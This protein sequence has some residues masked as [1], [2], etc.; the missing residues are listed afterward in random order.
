MKPPIEQDRHQTLTYPLRLP[1]EVKTQL[2]AEA[3]K[4]RRSL[5]GEIV[6]R[7]EKSL[8]ADQSTSAKGAA[9]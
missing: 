2:A 7:L 4:S 9:Q 6:S 5:N 1:S 3:T 8:A